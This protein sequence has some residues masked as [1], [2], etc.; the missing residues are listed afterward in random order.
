MDTR[1]MYNT[2]SSNQ[3]YCPYQALGAMTDTHTRGSGSIVH[4]RPQG[5]H[6]LSSLR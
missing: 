4:G 3:E 1:L 2:S 6:L 5:L